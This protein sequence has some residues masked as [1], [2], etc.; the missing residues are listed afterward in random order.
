MKLPFTIIKTSKLD[1][2]KNDS[3]KYNQRFT[4]KTLTGLRDIR[5][6]LLADIKEIDLMIKAKVANLPKVIKDK[7]IQIKPKREIHKIRTKL[8]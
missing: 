8:R 7:T 4:L 6:K 2:L 5:E 1:K 3:E